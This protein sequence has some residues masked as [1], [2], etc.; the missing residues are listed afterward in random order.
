LP[1]TFPENP[2]KIALRGSEG[3]GVSQEGEVEGPQ[4]GGAYGRKMLR[5]ARREKLMLSERRKKNKVS[6]E[7][8]KR[9]PG[10]EKL[11]FSTRGK[12]EVPRKGE[13]I[14]LLVFAKTLGARLHSC[15]KGLRHTC[16]FM[17]GSCGWR[18]VL[19]SRDNSHHY[20]ST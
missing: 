3:D 9:S 7:K 4:E 13:R 11:L 14:W 12:D 19:A 6:G 2:V 8:T 17:H 10:R 1:A 5:L 15:L 20:S 16:L 18:G